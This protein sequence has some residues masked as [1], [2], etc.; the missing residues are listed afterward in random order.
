VTD[1]ST[2][3]DELLTLREACELLFGNRIKPA[4]LRS[5]YARGRLE[6]ERI[7]R[8]QFVTRRAIREMRER[9]RERREP[10]QPLHTWRPD[11]SDGLAA[12]AAL[13]AR[14]DARREPRRPASSPTGAGITPLDAPKATLKGLTE[15]SE[16]TKTVGG[17]GVRT[18]KAATTG[19]GPQ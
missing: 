12:Q 19:G 8:Q 1:N 14:L 15:L 18:R 10:P 3:E 2:N 9:C 6:I 16:P 7:G 11:P 4:T 5:E 17:V 13:Q